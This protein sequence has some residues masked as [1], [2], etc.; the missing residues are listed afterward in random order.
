MTYI[1]VVKAIKFDEDWLKRF[2]IFSK[3]P[4]GVGRREHFAPPSPIRVKENQVVFLQ[5]FKKFEVLIVFARQTTDFRLLYTIQKF[6]L[7]FK[8]VYLVAP[9]LTQEPNFEIFS[10]SLSI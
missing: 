3:N 7:D 1:I 9:V 2:N 10:S 5:G 4:H 6:A 8:F